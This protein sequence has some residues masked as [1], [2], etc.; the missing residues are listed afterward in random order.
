M[1][2]LLIIPNFVEHPEKEKT[3]KLVYS[4]THVR[5]DRRNKLVFQRAQLTIRDDSAVSFFLPPS[6]DKFGRKTRLL[7]NP[8]TGRYK[9]INAFYNSKTQFSP[10]MPNSVL[11]K[12]KN[13]KLVYSSTHVRD[14]R[15]NFWFLSNYPIYIMI[16]IRY[17]L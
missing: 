7:F 2:S 10:V 4:S 13:E 15:K 3:K 12:R 9:K 16:P 11:K 8:R 6:R 1:S 5:D 14:D 17:A